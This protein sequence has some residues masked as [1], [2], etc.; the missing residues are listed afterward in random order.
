M[1]LDDINDEIDTELI[2]ENHETLSG[3]IIELL[4]YIPDESK[5]KSEE[6]EFNN[7]VFRILEM[8]DKRIEKVLLKILPKLEENTEEK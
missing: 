1:S 2:S 8:K 6:I 7:Y 4:G 3:M 5:M